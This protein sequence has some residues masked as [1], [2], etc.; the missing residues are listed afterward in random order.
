MIDVLDRY[1]LTGEL[2]FKNAVQKLLN[3]K[4]TVEQAMDYIMEFARGGWQVIVDE[5]LESLADE[6]ANLNY[7]VVKIP[8]GMSDEEIRRQFADKGVFITSNDRDF[9]LAEVPVPFVE[10]LLLV[11]N[12][13]HERLLSR[14][15]ERLLMNWRKQHKSAPVAVGIHRDDVR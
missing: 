15:I 12:G 1:G 4:A 7:R 5:N 14:T 13:L 6:L 2:I 10:G 9:D 3:G 8:K 11:P